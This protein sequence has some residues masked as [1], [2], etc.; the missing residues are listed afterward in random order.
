MILYSI[1]QTIPNFL[2]EFIPQQVTASGEVI[3]F[4]VVEQALVRCS[5]KAGRQTFGQPRKGL[6]AFGRDYVCSVS[7]ARDSL[8]VYLENNPRFC[9]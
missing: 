3:H 4:S 1:S 2:L 5:R 8:H 6:Y 7:A 9:A